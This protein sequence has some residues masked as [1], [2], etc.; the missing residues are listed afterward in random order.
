MNSFKTFTR[1]IPKKKAWSKWD[2][3]LRFSD[4]EEEEET[5]DELRQRAMDWLNKR[6]LTLV[7]VT[8]ISVNCIK[9]YYT[10]K[11]QKDN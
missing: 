10:G 9:V 11:P 7:G 2:G 3:E 1:I 6:K 5:T 4:S 8:E